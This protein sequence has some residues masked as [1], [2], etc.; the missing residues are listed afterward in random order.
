MARLP[1][2]NGGVVTASPWISRTNFKVATK[3]AKSVRGRALATPPCPPTPSATSFSF[4]GR[5]AIK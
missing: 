4:Y 3:V 1:N 2:C 5:T